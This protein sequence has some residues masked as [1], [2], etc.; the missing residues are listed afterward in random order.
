M[1]TWTQRWTEV[2]E[3]KSKSKSQGHVA[4][5]FLFI[6]SGTNIHLD[7]KVKWLEFSGQGQGHGDLMSLKKNAC[8]AW[9]CN[10]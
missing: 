10:C 3:Q 4:S 2:K 7:P 6:I 8:R 1:F 5:W 9:N